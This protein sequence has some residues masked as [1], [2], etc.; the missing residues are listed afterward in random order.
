MARSVVRYWEKWGGQ[1]ER[2]MRE[3]VSAFNHSQDRF[4]VE[5][6]PA[7]DWSSSPDLPRFLAAQSSGNTPDIIGL[8]DHQVVDLAH[9][10][11]PAPLHR[12]AGDIFLPAFERL[13]KVGGIPYAVPVSVNIA[14]LYVNLKALPAG[15]RAGWAEKGKP[16]GSPSEVETGVT[17]QQ[18]P[19]GT[20]PFPT[21]IR[22]FDDLLRRIEAEGRV[23]M[24]P[25]YPGWWPQL[26]PYLFG[27]AWFRDGRF[28]PDSPANVR[29]YQWVVDLAGRARNLGE[30]RF[31]ASINP[32]GRL[33]PDPFV[34]GQVAMV[35]EG[36]WLVWRLVQHPDL[37]W[38][39]APLPS[40][41]GR[42]QALA[43]ADVLCIPRGARNP[44]GAQAFIDFA[45]Q[46]PNI[47]ALAIGQNKISPLRVWSQHFIDHHPNPQIERF[48]HILSSCDLVSDPRV[49][50]WL[51]H[52]ERI[53]SAFNDIWS[54]HKTAEEALS[55]PAATG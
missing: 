53:K 48:H 16:S 40:V 30:R 27:G 21:D 45:S 36:D 2:A 38:V 17:V 10:N 35:V 52:L 33:D 22:S 4:F 29:A 20:F 15:D 11:V 19:G 23:G 32:I 49:R 50:G 18:D 37:E 55:S 9:E 13:G 43:V 1:E 5:M 3:I 41:D 7:G 54:G 26:W 42:P 47:E 12:C 46:A 6:E 25:S 51:G 14:T 24:I 28:E 34:S 31:S 44:E 8:E 39:P